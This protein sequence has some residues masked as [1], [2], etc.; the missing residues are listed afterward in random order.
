MR[1]LMLSYEFPP[2]GGG[3]GN[4][5]FHV[6]KEFSTETTLKVDLI[7]SGDERGPER[8][9]FSETTEVYRLPIRKKRRDF[10]TA[11][12]LG[13]WA[14]KAYRL[15]RLLSRD[16]R[17]DLCHC[18]SG[19]PAGVIGY[20]LRRNQP[21]LVALRGSDVPGFN[22]RLRLLD[23]LVFRHISRPVWRRAAVITAVSRNLGKLAERT[24]SE[25]PI[26][27]I[28]NGVDAVQFSPNGGSDVFTVLFVGRLVPR[29]G[30][31]HLL[32]AFAAVL[33]SHPG[34][35]LIIAGEGPERERLETLGE[36]LNLGA[37]VTFRGHVEHT[38][39]PDLYR[40]AS[41]FVLPAL[42][43]GM[44]N[45]LLE[46]MASGLPTVTTEGSMDE[47][48]QDNGI[49]VAKGN[50]GQLAEAIVGY[51]RDP[52]LATRHGASSLAFARGRP[53]SEKAKAYLRLYDEL[54]E[55]RGQ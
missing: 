7:T 27:V 12:E 25:R 48:V 32:Q 8:S 13:E 49:V 16:A 40:Q 17:Y 1:I 44:S 50:P 51:A 33:A 22:E 41:V 20:L 45:A 37:S 47:M 42:R 31:D 19:W 54:V 2:L 29:K 26:R 10:W 5:C 6:L 36:R 3:T 30:V 28:E 43:E 11:A 24:S 34:A 9:T 52:E 14:L 15:T 53:W 55:R 23:P 35:R 21:Y 18:W 46:A 38:D 39:L 4:A